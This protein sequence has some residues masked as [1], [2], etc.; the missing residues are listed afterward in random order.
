MSIS[1]KI[2]DLREL[3]DGLLLATDG[4]GPLLQ[5]DYWAVEPGAR[6]PPDDWGR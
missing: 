4:V 3:V 2:G 1:E 5:R 6:T